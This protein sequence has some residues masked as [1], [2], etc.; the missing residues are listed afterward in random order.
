MTIDRGFMSRRACVGAIALGVWAPHV[1]AQS[2]TEFDTSRNLRIIV[3]YAPGGPADILARALAQQLGKQLGIQVLVEN[4]G[5]AGGQLG[6]AAIAKAVP[7]GYT[8]GLLAESPIT[9]APHLGQLPYKP[10]DLRPV[11]SLTYSPVALCATSAFTGKTFQSFIESARAQPG[12]MR[13]ASAGGYGT[14]GHVLIESIQRSSGVKLT[15]IP[16]KGGAQPVLD[17]LS[18]SFEVLSTNFDGA[19][20]QHIQSGK[21]RLLAVTGPTRTPEFPDIPTLKQ[22]GY[23]QANLTT[24]FALFAPVN[25][26]RPLLRTLHEHVNKALHAPELDKVIRDAASQRLLSLSPEAY[27]GQIAANSAAFSILIKGEGL[28]AAP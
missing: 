24:T 6:A 23:P 2:L 15:M 13:M 1:R 18:G 9:I 21:L 12:A 7:D 5:G 25:A 27:A 28:H 19:L 20:M 16:Y 10:D 8:I 11:A 22:L 26:P 4:K 14:P 3:G 17:A